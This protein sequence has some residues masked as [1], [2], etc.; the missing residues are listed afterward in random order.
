MKTKIDT[1]KYTDQ[2]LVIPADICKIIER[3]NLLAIPADDFSLSF[4]IEI[5]K[6]KVSD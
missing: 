6:V 3:E 5:V 2:T 4:E 1:T